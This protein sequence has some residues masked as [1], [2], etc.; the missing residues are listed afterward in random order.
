MTDTLPQTWSK[1][2]VCSAYGISVDTLDRLIRA[3][4]VGYILGKKRSRRFLAVNLGQIRE[5]LEVKATHLA[6]DDRLLIGMTSA[7]ARRR[8]RA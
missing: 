8:R 6:S 1:A 3:G 4:R 2:E 5:A 7:A